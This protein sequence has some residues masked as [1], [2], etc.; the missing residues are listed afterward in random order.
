MHG[1]S[2]MKENELITC[3]PF[4]GVEIEWNKT[5]KCKISPVPVTSRRMCAMVIQ[6][7]GHNIMLFNVYMPHSMLDVIQSHLT[8]YWM[9]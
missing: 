5:I 4:G 3:R 8:R 6:V 1:I 9:K 2:G 7:N